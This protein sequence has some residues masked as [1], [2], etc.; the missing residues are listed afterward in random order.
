MAKVLISSKNQIGTI[1]FLV[2][3]PNKFHNVVFR[4]NYIDKIIGL[5]VFHSL[6]QSLKF[7]QR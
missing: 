2:F 6:D 5:A 3:F 7:D 1:I 4:L